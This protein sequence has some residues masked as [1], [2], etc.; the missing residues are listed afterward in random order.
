MAENYYEDEDGILRGK[1]SIHGEFVG[2]AIGCPQCFADSE[3]AEANAVEI[4]GTCDFCGKTHPCECEQ[5]NDECEICPYCKIN[6]VDIDDFGLTC[7]QACFDAH[8]EWKSKFN[9]MARD[10]AYN[11]GHPVNEDD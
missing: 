1:C 7:C 4:K 2:D 11:S 3:N 8:P 10:E 5:D 6:P 9:E